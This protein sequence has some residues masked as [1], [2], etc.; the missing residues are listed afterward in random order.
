MAR[1]IQGSPFWW[2]DA[3]QPAT[4]EL[5]ERLFPLVG[6]KPQAD[7]RRAQLGVRGEA[8]G[9]LE[10][11]TDVVIARSQLVRHVLVV[12]RDLLFVRAHAPLEH[13]QRIERGLRLGDHGAI[14][15]RAHLLAQVADPCAAAQDERAAVGRVH[16]REHPQER[17][18][19]G[20]VAADEPDAVVGANVQRRTLEERAPGTRQAV[21]RLGLGR[22]KGLRKEAVQCIVAARVDGPFVD[23]TD[24]SRRA[25]LDRSMVKALSRAGALASLAGNRHHAAWA[26]L[27]IETPLAVL[28]EARIREAAPLLRTPSEGEDIVADYAHLGFTLG[29]HPLALLR[30]HLRRR[31]CVTAAQIAAAQPGDRV[32]AA[33]LVISRQRPGTATGV[34]FV[35]LEDETGTINVIVWSTLVEAQRRELL[36]ARL[37]GVLG[38]VQRDGEVVHLIAH[39]LSDH[40]SLLGRLLA[41]SRDFH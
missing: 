38:E 8:A 9:A 17:G 23:V 6:A 15:D 16:A 26:A 19:T 12:A 18:L 37:L 20:A 32:R 25:G 4:G 1:S 28:P 39:S 2:M 30:A 10:F 7:Q 24:L 36:H 40:S 22:V 21:V 29:R 27:G 3:H 35:T 33:G 11:V 41:A 14:G 31:Q 34:V 13:A 5:G